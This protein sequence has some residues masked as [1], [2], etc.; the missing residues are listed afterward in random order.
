MTPIY[1]DFAASAPVH[2]EVWDAMR[3]W[4]LKAGNSAS[5]HAFGRAGRQALDAARRTIATCLDCEPDEILF[6][7]G[8]TEANN[9]A[10]FGLAGANPGVIA[11]SQL[12]HPCV[13]EP[14]KQ[15]ALRGFRLQEMPVSPLGVIDVS[16]IAWANDV[17]VAAMMLVNHE[18][19]AIQ[20]VRQLRTSLPSIVPLHCDAAAAVGKLPVSFRDLGAA[21]L[22]LSAHK[23]HGPPGIGALIVRRG[24]RLQP[25]MFGGHQQHG[26]RPGTEPIALVVGMAAALDIAYRNLAAK[27]EPVRRL[28]DRFVHAISSHHG[29]DSSKLAT[30]STIAVVNSPDAAI[31]HIV[32]ISFPGLQGDALL[33]A[34]DLAGVACSTGSACSSG[35]LLPSPVLKAMAL[36]DDRLRSALRFSFSDSLSDTEIDDAIRRIVKTVK[37]LRD[38]LDEHE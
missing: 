11:F 12:E 34:L 7:S 14:I 17:R 26:K 3:P 36:P 23:F 9:L 21:T 1:L 15:L 22:S 2:P 6:T 31:P 5:S 24:V 4:A 10:I 13:I 28:R 20:P 38:S 32:N 30:C 35:S 29:A 33:M 8:A 16:A 27:T 25:Q 19:G 18:T 37:R